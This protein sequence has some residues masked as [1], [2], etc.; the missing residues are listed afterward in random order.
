M[1]VQRKKEEIHET[2]LNRIGDILIDLQDETERL[3][4]S[5]IGVT[6]TER[7]KQ[8]IEYSRDILRL[9]LLLFR[10]LSLRGIGGQ[11]AEH[12]LNTVQLSRKG[13][14]IIEE[15]YNA[16]GCNSYADALEWFRVNEQYAR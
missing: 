9:K 6:E 5:C 7:V 4:A 8:R 15:I 13:D 2:A 16:I 12:P 11:E 10:C 3:I 1:D 14:D